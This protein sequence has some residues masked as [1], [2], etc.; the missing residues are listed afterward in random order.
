LPLALLHFR[1][2][3]PALFLASGR[4]DGLAVCSDMNCDGYKNGGRVFAAG[5][6][7]YFIVQKT[8]LVKLGY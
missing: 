2:A 8:S 6:S 7:F 1:P 5:R 3:A 4:L